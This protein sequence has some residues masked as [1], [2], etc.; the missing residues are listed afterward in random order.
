M[1]D[2][3]PRASLHSRTCT[4]LCSILVISGQQSVNC[5]SQSANGIHSVNKLILLGTVVIG[6]CKNAAKHYIYYRTYLITL[7]T[8]CDSVLVCALVRVC[9]CMHV[10]VTDLHLASVPCH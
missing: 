2:L 6:P 9:A 8:V 10:C 1:S 4:A 7:P 3:A 5:I